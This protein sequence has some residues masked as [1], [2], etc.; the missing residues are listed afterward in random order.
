MVSSI[1]IY[2][3]T[4]DLMISFNHCISIVYRQNCGLIGVEWAALP[5]LKFTKT[6]TLLG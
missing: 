6:G 1:L 4:N 3:K 2:F 5:T